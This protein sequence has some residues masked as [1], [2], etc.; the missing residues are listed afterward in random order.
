M[1][2]EKY[3]LFDVDE[4]AEITPDTPAKKPRRK[5]KP[6]YEG[7][8]LPGVDDEIYV[9]VSAKWTGRR[10]NCTVDGIVSRED[11]KYV[12][13]EAGCCRLPMFYPAKSNNNGKGPC[14]FLGD[15]GCTMEL[16]D[17]PVTCNLFPLRLNKNNTL[18]GWGRTYLPGAACSACAN[19]GP[20]MIEALRPG[21]VD[22]FGEGQTDAAI[23]SVKRGI[24][25]VLVVRPEV[26]GALLRE[27]E[28]EEQLL[29]PEP[30]SEFVEEDIERYRKSKALK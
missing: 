19:E 9:K 22:L 15:K 18:V 21:L 23:E 25:P 5:L 29:I 4:N 17:R 1:P 27:E 24:D 30:R 8:D 7:E 28:W 3:P 10:L 2:E 20:L 13:C 11:P 12:G 14:Y 16:K 26:M 6:D